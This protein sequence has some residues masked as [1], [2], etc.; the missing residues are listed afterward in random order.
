VHYLLLVDGYNI[1]NQW[2]SLKHLSQENM[3]A[4]RHQL[5]L[6]LSRYGT[7]RWNRIIVIFDAYRVPLKNRTLFS[8]A[9]GKVEIYYTRQ[10]ETADYFI[11]KLCLDFKDCFKVEVASSDRLV[12]HMAGE[13][14]A[15]LLSSEGLSIRLAQEEK[16]ARRK[17]AG[18]FISSK[19]APM[20]QRLPENILKNF[21]YG[22]RKKFRQKKES[23]NSKKKRKN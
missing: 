9:Y 22:D 17:F 19:D 16:E 6:K 20:N 14:G 4:A 10:G 1:I 13:A 7:V 8:E 11:E 15:R 3:E 18:T 21:M 23:K 12:L 2:E 5:I